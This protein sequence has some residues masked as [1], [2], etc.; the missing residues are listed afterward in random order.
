M[1]ESE[2]QHADEAACRLDGLFRDLFNQEDRHDIIKVV[3]ATVDSHRSEQKRKNC[4]H[5]N[6]LGNGSLSSD[7]SSSFSWFCPE[8]GSSG[9]SESSRPHGAGEE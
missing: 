6:R 8:C 1:T 9:N 5:F 2:I 4:R 7:G 3:I